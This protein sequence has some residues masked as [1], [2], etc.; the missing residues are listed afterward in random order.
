M[1]KVIFEA[2]P[3]QTT[4]YHDTHGTTYVPKE[5][6]VWATVPS[7]GNDAALIAVF[8]SEVGARELAR[9]MNSLSLTNEIFP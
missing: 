9:L 1:Q 5:W 6:A 7:A 8:E 3:G 2:K 4:A